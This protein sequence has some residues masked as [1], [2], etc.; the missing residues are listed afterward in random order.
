M[1]CIFVVLNFAPFSEGWGV[2]SICRQNVLKIETTWEQVSDGGRLQRSSEN[3][4]SQKCDQDIM[5]IKEKKTWPEI[6]WTN[7]I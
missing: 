7:F 4:Q 2:R 6:T 5:M 3:E 1:L